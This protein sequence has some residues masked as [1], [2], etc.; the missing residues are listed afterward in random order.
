MKEAEDCFLRVKNDYLKFL[1]KEKIF[2]KS[3]T[4]KIASLK[5]TYNPAIELLNTVIEKQTKLIVDWMRVGFIHG[6]MNT[7]N[8]TVSGETIDYGPCAFMDCYDPETVFSSIDYQGRY[9]FFNQPGIA[10]WNLARFAESLIPLINDKKDVFQSIEI[11][12]LKLRL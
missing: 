2:N 4:T 3:K 12:F 10:K 8:M 7:D 9:A 5:K 6:V 11:L 1:K